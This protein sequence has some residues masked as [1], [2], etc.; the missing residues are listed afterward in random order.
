MEGGVL[1]MRRIKLVVIP[2][3]LI[4]AIAAILMARGEEKGETKPSGA[5]KI[6]VV[7]INTV[8]EKYTLTQELREAFKKEVA[9]KEE[10]L[11][12]KQEELSKM[13]ADF[14]AQ[15]PVL[16][17]EARAERIREQMRKRDEL[18]RY[19][20]ETRDAL[21]KKE[22]E[23]ISKIIP[24]I[25]DVVKQIAEQRG[26]DIVLEKASL[27]YSSSSLDITNDV[28]T[29]LNQRRAPKPEGE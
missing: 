19:I 16:S 8:F 13:E 28:I 25:H 4:A 1:E 15:S 17:K 18:N 11:K 9:E 10:E 27:L 20:A 7:D 29:M 12:R 24:D 2:L 6:G 5:V 14:Y 26:L 23:L 22:S 21:R 3:V